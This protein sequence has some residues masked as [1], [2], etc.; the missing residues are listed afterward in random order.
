MSISNALSNAYSGLTAVSRAAEVVSNNVANANTEGYHRQQVNLSARVTGTQG[1]GVTTD[2]VSRAQDLVAMT[3]RRA[4][5]AGME[6]NRVETSA[7][8]KLSSALG[9]PG[10]AGALATQ[11]SSLETS[12]RQLQSTPDSTGL[13]QNLLSTA[14]GLVQIF[15]RI[16]AETTAIRV[17]ADKN[18]ASLVTTVNKSLEQIQGLNAE[19]RMLGMSGRDAAA[20][21]DKRQALIDKVNAIIPIR[22]SQSTTGEAVLFTQGG[23]ILLNGTPAKLGFSNTALMTPDM[24]LASGAL[25]G[26][27]LNSQPVDIGVASGP[28]EGGT[29]AANFRVRDTIAMDFQTQIDGLARDLLERFQDPSVDPTIP[30]GTPA[31]FTDTG[32]FFLAANETGVA[33][34]LAVNQAVDPE[35]GGALWRLRDGL[36]AASPGLAGNTAIITKMLDTLVDTRPPVASTGIVNEMSA[37]GFAGEIT[38]VWG[39]EADQRQEMLSFDTSHHLALRQQELE[40]TGVDTDREMRDLMTV[41]QAYAANARVMSVID[42]LMKTLM[43][44]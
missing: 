37:A 13:Q 12:L 4:A 40:S 42:G 28:L 10:E 21:M 8:A 36:G 1:T 43:E 2:G 23:G 5:E 19:I 17:R 18:I 26:L 3:A 41:E 31:L 16:S 33:G 29:L 11:Y 30:A 6:H 14:K 44:I 27:T 15:N 7:I 24:T 34:R 32:A 35:N 25:S 22:Q 9:L 20:L 38:A 39:L